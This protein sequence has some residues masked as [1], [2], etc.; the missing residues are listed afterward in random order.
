MK[1][2]IIALSVAAAFL[3][4][5]IIAVLKKKQYGKI[6]EAIRMK[7]HQR[8]AVLC[9]DDLTKFLFPEMY[10]DTLRLDE[11]MIRNDRAEISYVLARLLKADLSER[12]RE[13]IYAQA[14]NYYLSVH[15]ERRCREW[16]GRIQKLKNQSLIRE[17]SRTYNIYIEK[18]DRYLDEMLEELKETEPEKAGA[19][20]YLISLMYANRKDR[21]NEK[22]FRELA[23][24]H[25]KQLDEKIAGNLSKH[26]KE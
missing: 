4:A 3:L 21:A 17:C 16:F 12:D 22:K 11:A 19:N 13:K 14:Y 1:N 24:T 25:L 9:N 18:G 15:D 2:A 26:K 8:F 10:L 23:Q 20:E 6:L 7:D 5:A